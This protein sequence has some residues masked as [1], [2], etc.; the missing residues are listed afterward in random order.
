MPF[1]VINS[2]VD[3][4]DDRSAAVVQH[5]PLAVAPDDCESGGGYEQVRQLIDAR[6][7]EAAFRIDAAPFPVG[8]AQVLQPG[9][10]EIRATVVHERHLVP[11][12]EDEPVERRD[13]VAFP[14][15][16]GRWAIRENRHFE[17]V[18]FVF[19]HRDA[20]VE[21]VFPETAAPVVLQGDGRCARG[22]DE[23]PFAVE[24]YGGPVADKLP[25]IFVT[26][27]PENG[28]AVFVGEITRR[29]AAG[30]RAVDIARRRT[31]TARGRRLRGKDAFRKDD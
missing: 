17:F 22:V 18:D 5:A 21:P 7:D 8:E 3:A 23:P 26:G 2:V 31:T 29:S 10:R 16:Q 9:V 24:P 6:H 15:D 30:S 20:L 13:P 25:G 28:V 27:I 12:R 1:F 19:D 14:V 11:D 4:R